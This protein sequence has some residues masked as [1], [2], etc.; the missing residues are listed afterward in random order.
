MLI[1]NIS[2]CEKINHDWHSYKEENS[3]IINIRQRSISIVSHSW[4]IIDEKTKDSNSKWE[5]K[6]TIN[7]NKDKNQ[8]RK[9]WLGIKQI[10]YTLYDEDGFKLTEIVSNLDDYE[11]ERVIFDN[12]KNGPVLQECGSERTYRDTGFIKKEL[13]QRATIGKC[14]ILL[15][16]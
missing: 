7:I 11:D 16:Y 6:V 13:I 2:G 5:F 1:F 12:G 15:D 9:C 10:T 8:T 4:K 3:K 14:K